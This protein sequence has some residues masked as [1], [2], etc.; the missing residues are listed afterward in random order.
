MKYQIL[1]AALC[2]LSGSGLMAQSK[3]DGPARLLSLPGTAAPRHISTDSDSTAARHTFI[4]TT[5]PYALSD[6]DDA[7]VEYISP[8]VALVT[9]ATD[10]IGE[11]AARDD[12]DFVSASV[13]VR[14]LLDKALPS[15]HATEVHNGSG[16]LESAYDGSGVLVALMDTGLDPNHRT[17]LNDDGTNRAA[18]VWHF[19]G[20]QGACH[21]YAG[22]EIT[23]FTSDNNAETHGTHV[24]GIMTGS[25]D[26]PS[27][28]AKVSSSIL[29]PRVTVTDG[30]M[31]YVG[32]APGATP[33]IG[34]GPLYS[35]NILSLVSKAVSY[36]EAEG[37][38]LVINLSLGINT[39]PHDGTDSF[40]RA[41]AGCVGDAIVCISAG[42]E[43]DLPISLSTTFA[44]GDAPLRTM[45]TC[46]ESSVHYSGP[47]DIWGDDDTPLNV[48]WVVFDTQEEQI[49]CEL[50]V[51]TDAATNVSMGYLSSSDRDREFKKHFSGY[52]TMSQSVNPYNNRS[53]VY[54]SA[55]NIRPT[56][57]NSGQRYRLGIVVNES[58]GQGVRIY[59]EGGSGFEFT[60]L[61]KEGWTDGNSEQSINDMACGPDVIAVGSYTTKN[62]YGTLAGDAY[63]TG[64]TVNRIS[65]F[66]SWGTLPDGT[67][68][69][70][71]TAPGDM[72][73]AP[74]SSYYVSRSADPSDM[75][76]KV[77][78]IVHTTDYYDTLCGTSMASPA[79]SGT[80]ALWLQADPTLTRDRVLEVMRETATNDSRTA[81]APHRFGYGKINAL[82]GLKNVIA[83]TA[84]GTVGTDPSGLLAVEA[85]ES[86]LTATILGAS[87]VTA[88]LFTVSGVGAVSGSGSDGSVT[89]H[90][91]ALLPGIYI[92]RVTSAAGEVSR[93]VAIR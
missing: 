63:R 35:S 5:G 70:Q 87:D 7:Q 80:I 33:L 20:Y 71:I 76:A 65:P 34:C 6:L 75:A 69:P 64:S 52:V 32:V 27:T 50:A 4:I 29:V 42:N 15:I 28:Y 85:G 23:S 45:L 62:V 68:L 3:L 38:P 90:T 39:G 59:T 77:D 67:T 86:S 30:A 55:T 12:V 14:P 56:S 53:N 36:A 46:T 9:I 61:G 1:T 17:F 18:R 72:I 25:Y 81:A 93:R 16:A 22:G 92:L 8:T 49:V 21:E 40:S 48:S 73:T 60:G 41:L 10:R 54:C 57:A 26:G 91:D 19:S 24:L 37:K 47:V 88:T 51:P 84:L 31:P 82:E 43:G 13:P 44:D 11:V 89:L 58:V 74:V 78:G 79:V 66:S 83:G 2:L